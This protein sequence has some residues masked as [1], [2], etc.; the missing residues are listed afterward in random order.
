MSDLVYI[1]PLE[2]EVSPTDFVNLGSLAEDMV[3]RLPGC[4][5]LMIRKTLQAVYREFCEMTW[6][7]RSVSTNEL[8]EGE[9]SYRIIVPSQTYVFRVVKVKKGNSI[10]AE[11]TQFTAMTGQPIRIV[12]SSVPSSSDTGVLLETE[13]VCVPTRGSEDVPV[14]F[15]DMYGSALVSG[16]LFRLFAMESK[17]WT[18]VSQAKLEGIMW[19][20]SLNDATAKSIS[21]S[22]IGNKQLN[23]INFEGML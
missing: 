20:N 19:Q 8:V 5:D 21:G 15:S 13:V 12:L 3:Y 10:L 6:A 17:P 22:Q 7:L 14:W 1:N 2:E 4:A 23:A 11:G 9:A 18:D 16:A